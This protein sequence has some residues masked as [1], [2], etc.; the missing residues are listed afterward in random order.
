MMFDERAFCKEN[1]LKE[2]GE[3]CKREQGIRERKKETCNGK[4]N[5]KDTHTMK[6]RKFSTT[7]K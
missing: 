3:S 4:E 7:K 2:R 6:K 1:E 5:V